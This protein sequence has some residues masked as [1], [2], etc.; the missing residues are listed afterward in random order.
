MDF[1][2]VGDISGVETKDRVFGNVGA[3]A[4][5]MDGAGGASVRVLR[6]SDS[7]QEIWSEQ[8]YTG[9]RLPASVNAK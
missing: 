3:C 9:M 6:K 1:E 2:I 8:S 7:H 4:N 5:A